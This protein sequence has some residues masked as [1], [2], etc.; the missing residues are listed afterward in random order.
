MIF[1]RISEVQ[2]Q[3]TNSKQTV[4][5]A[6]HRKVM[7]STTLSRKYVRRPH[8]NT[9]M[10]VNV[11]RSPKIQHFDSNVASSAWQNR[12]VTQTPV[13]PVKQEQTFEGKNQCK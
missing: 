8:I 11:K 4:S 12:T 5:K 3:K 2:M 7:S 1:I 10:V 6:A 9:D 13:A